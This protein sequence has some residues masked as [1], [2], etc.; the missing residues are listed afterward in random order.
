MSNFMYRVK[1]GLLT[2]FSNQLLMT[3]IPGPIKKAMIK[4][5][6]KDLKLVLTDQL[7]SELKAF[8]S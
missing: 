1:I 4:E 5:Y 2:D 7:A 6:A 3:N 8:L